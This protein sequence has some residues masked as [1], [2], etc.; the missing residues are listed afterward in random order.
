[1]KSKRFIILI[2]AL[3]VVGGTSTSNANFRNIE[4][5]KNVTE[6]PNTNYE[7]LLSS[8]GMVDIGLELPK[9][10]INLKYASDDN[11]VGYNFY[12]AQTKA[13]V[14]PECITKLKRAY[15]L[16]QVKYPGYSFVIFDATRSVEAQKIMWEKCTKP[17]S[18]RFYYVAN[19]YTTGSL[20]N[21]GMALDLNIVDNNGAQL[22]MGTNFDYFGTLAH[23]TQTE[24]FYQ[25]G[26]LTQEQYENRLLLKTIMEAAGFECAKCE[27]WHFN[28]CS[29]EE[30]VKKYP[31]YSENNG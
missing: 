22:N 5:D 19:P 25:N 23:T 8:M 6:M 18:Q 3:I 28:A 31:I 11:F 27:W 30:A 24:Y 9:C 13:Y 2:F 26:I 15:D 12:G 1:M 16:L 14:R 7:L 20:H 10:H 4:L 29:L 21:Y 17:V